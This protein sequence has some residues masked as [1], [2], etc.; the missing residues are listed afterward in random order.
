MTD[1]QFTRAMVGMVV[2]FVA[3]F[4]LLI[5]VSSTFHTDKPIKQPGNVVYIT[6]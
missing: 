5:G 4:V 1:K 3:A 2:G 6:E